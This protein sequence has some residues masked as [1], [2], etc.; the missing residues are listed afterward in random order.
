MLK[1]RPSI[2]SQI[3]VLLLML[4]ILS[5][6]RL[7]SCLGLFRTQN[8]KDQIGK[9]FFMEIIILM[10]WVIW[11]CRNNLIFNNSVPTVQ[12]CKAIFK[13]EFSSMLWHAKRKY[14]PQIE[15]WI[16]NLVQIFPPHFCSFFTSFVSLSLELLRAP[17][18]LTCTSFCFCFF[19]LQ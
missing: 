15:E 11:I 4:G 9:P 8:L 14:F 5:N 16:Q 19:Y 2:S 17:P 6:C 1:N 18:E 12:S 7:I 13:L 3:A 10:C